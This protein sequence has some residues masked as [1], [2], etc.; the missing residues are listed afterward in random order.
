M[1]EL[2][3]NN[4]VFEKPLTN[5]NSGFSRWGI[6]RRGGKA[7]FV[8][9]FL[10]PTYPAEETSFDKKQLE[11]KMK[12]C[13]EFK[14][15]KLNLYRTINEASD[16]NIVRIHQFFRVKAKYYISTEVVSGVA[17]SVREISTLSI[18]ERLTIC[19]IVA[20]SVALL[21][22]KKIIHADI[23]P[24]N[25][26]VT[27]NK[28]CKAKIIDFDCSFFENDS[29]EIGEEL[30]GDL[31]YL[32]PEAFCHMA[33]IESRL[34]CK[35]DIFALGILF[36]QYL[37]GELPI[38]DKNNYTYIYEAIL[39]KRNVRVLQTIPMNLDKLLLWMLK[40]DPENRPDA[41]TVF[42]VLREKLKQLTGRNYFSRAGDL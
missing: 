24:D 2:N 9:E 32:S 41:K 21:H 23:K 1:E 39:D 19:C 3:I 37:T 35:M 15:S 40:A 5:D 28:F 27:K 10:S 11:S 22:E 34:S 38:Y 6:G 26:L 12:I 20:H 13:K 36:H 18:Q 16:G 14:D 31:V 29:P 25:V 30:G 33:E 7:Y 17:L 42:Y 4:Y 8:K